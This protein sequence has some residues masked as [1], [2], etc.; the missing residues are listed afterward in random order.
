[1]TITRTTSLDEAI[2]HA[3]ATRYGLQGAIFTSDIQTALTAAARLEFGGVMI[4]EAPTFRADQMPYGGI[5]AS[6]NTKE[7]PGWAVRE[8]TEERLVVL[9]T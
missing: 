2:R 3:N 9:Q 6:G 7:G 1:V 4:N 5:K 8:M